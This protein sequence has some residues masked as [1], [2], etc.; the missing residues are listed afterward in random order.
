MT[1]NTTA[2]SLWAAETGPALLH[3]LVMAF[4]VLVLWVSLARHR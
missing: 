2:A 4:A 1:S 3:L